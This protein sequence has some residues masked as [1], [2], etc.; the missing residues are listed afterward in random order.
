M[1]KK[2]KLVH[3]KDFSDITFTKIENYIIDIKD[4]FNNS[5]KLCESLLKKI[6]TYK[7]YLE[8]IDYSILHNPD[9]LKNNDI[10]EELKTEYNL[11]N[12]QITIN[13]ELSQSIVEELNNIITYEFFPE[14][15]NANIPNINSGSTFRD[16]KSYNYSEKFKT[17]ISFA[18][19]KEDSNIFINSKMDEENVN[20]NKKDKDEEDNKKYFLNSIENII[21]F[22]LL[23]CNDILNEKEINKNSSD[24][25][26]YPKIRDNPNENDYEKFLFQ[27]NDIAKG[28]I[29]LNNFSLNKLNSKILKKIENIYKENLV[30]NL[31]IDLN[32]SN[33]D[34][35]D[36]ESG[37]F[38]NEVCDGKSEK[39]VE[40]DNGREVI[41]EKVLNDYYYFINIIPKY[42]LKRNGNIKIKILR[43]LNINLENFL[44]S[45][46]T[47]YFIDNFVRTDNFL[48]LSLE[49]IKNIYPNLDELYEYKNIFDCLIKECNIK[50]NIDYRGNFIIKINNKENTKEKY[51]PPYE[52]IGIGLKVIG[53]YEND[54]WLMDDSKDSKWAIAYHGITN[55]IS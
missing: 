32:N 30:L 33:F 11:F 53:K 9:E 15:K 1:E 23:K 31:N 7:Y 8:K 35:E 12:E 2:C 43:K 16:N 51:Y 24:E 5:I 3:Y 19:K 6:K 34:D 20:D 41:D 46:N 50:D 10:Y 37:E 44:A 28:S 4:Y 21:K 38:I 36:E 45:S 18:D 48:N 26:N 54:E 27:I 49:Q 17:F 25:I 55:K 22:I 39:S 47:K 40:Q 29:N 14:G 42:N 52:W 13:K